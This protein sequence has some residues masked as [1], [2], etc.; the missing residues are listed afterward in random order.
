MSDKPFQRN[1]LIDGEKFVVD[2]NIPIPPKRQDMRKRASLVHK[3]AHG[4]SIQFPNYSAVYSFRS[5]VKKCGYNS[6]SRKIGTKTWRVW[7]I[8]E[9]K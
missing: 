4:D 9:E 1:I 8:K 6:E 3:M 7:I 5:L 2:A